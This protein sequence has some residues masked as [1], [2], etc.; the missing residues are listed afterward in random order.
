MNSN[1]LPSLTTNSFKDLNLQLHA[2][3]T[4]TN[5]YTFNIQGNC[6]FSASV[7]S[8]VP[9]T[10]T[11]LYYHDYNDGYVYTDKHFSITVP[12]G[13]TKLF[14]YSQG[15]QGAPYSGIRNANPEKTWVSASDTN[16]SIEVTTPHNNQKRTV[17]G[18]IIQVTP[19][20]TYNLYA[21]LGPV[22]NPQV[23]GALMFGL[24]YSKAINNMTA[25]V[26]DL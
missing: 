5:P 7:E 23:A 16:V 25:H 20:K 24:W 14:A 13:V 12:I 18:N 19:G 11:V 17:S 9:E 2:S 6:S 10:T 4:V 3:T 22:E 15:Y 21:S 1:G 8:A 26:V